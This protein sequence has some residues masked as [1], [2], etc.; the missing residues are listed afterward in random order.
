M[1]YDGKV[2]IV[3]LNPFGELAG[4][5]LFSWVTDRDLLLNEDGR[6]EFRIQETPPEKT[7]IKGELSDKVI[8][9]LNI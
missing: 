2:W 8:D 7:Y 4:S 9:F 1:D 3:E 6:Y 5:C